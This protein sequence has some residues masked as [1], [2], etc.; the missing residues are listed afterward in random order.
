[1]FKQYGFYVKPWTSE[2]EGSETVGLWRFVD[3]PYDM[4]S[5]ELE[6]GS[7]C[8]RMCPLRYR[9]PE[10]HAYPPN[11]KTSGIST[12]FLWR[13]GRLN[14]IRKCSFWCFPAKEQTGGRKVISIG[15]NNLTGV[16]FDR[17]TRIFLYQR[18]FT[19]IMIFVLIRFWILNL[20][21][22]RLF[23]C[24][25][26]MVIYYALLFQWNDE[27]GAPPQKTLISTLC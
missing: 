20:R 19:A 18:S 26:Q 7:I 14:Y 15:K 6:K 12:A 8:H 16:L 17:S 21:R 9:K 27:H 11:V 4:P 22:F 1:M 24:I 25:I 13:N 10:G 23:R 3:M 2:Y 5:T